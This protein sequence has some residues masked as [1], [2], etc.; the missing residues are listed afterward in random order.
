MLA[1]LLLD[2]YFKDMLYV[3]RDPQLISSKIGF[4]FSWEFVAIKM[5]YALCMVDHAIVVLEFRSRPNNVAGGNLSH[6]NVLIAIVVSGI[7]RKQMVLEF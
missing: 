1:L 2:S 4:C 5:P 3:G 7:E 6:N